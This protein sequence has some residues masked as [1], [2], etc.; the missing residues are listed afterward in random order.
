MT[1]QTTTTEDTM[2]TKHERLEDGLFN[3]TQA[4]RQRMFK[5]NSAWS[6]GAISNRERARHMRT[7][8]ARLSQLLDRQ[9]DLAH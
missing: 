7:L 6:R 4:T 3:R 5:L 9:Y 2:K 8:D 1:T